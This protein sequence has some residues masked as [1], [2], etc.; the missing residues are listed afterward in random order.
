MFSSIQIKTVT[1]NIYRYTDIH[2]LVYT[3]IL[4]SVYQLRGP[5][6]TNPAGTS[7]PSTQIFA[8][9]PSEKNPATNTKRSPW[10]LKAWLT[11]SIHSQTCRYRNF[12]WFHLQHFSTLLKVRHKGKGNLLPTVS[13]LISDRIHEQN[14]WFILPRFASFPE[15]LLIL[16]KNVFADH[17]RLKT[18]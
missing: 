9:W 8:L 1:S 11:A 15:L 3:P 2:Q 18:Y 4:C 12:K 10:K 6:S 13:F 17:A 7:T 14:K 5:K 16:P